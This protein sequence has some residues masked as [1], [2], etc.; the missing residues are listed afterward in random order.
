MEDRMRR[1][2]AHLIGFLKGGNVRVNSLGNNSWDY[3][4]IDK[5]INPQISE[6]H[7]TQGEL[8]KLTNKQTKTL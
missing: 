8:R 1:T 2:N 6:A 7:M 5:E 4:I 3:S